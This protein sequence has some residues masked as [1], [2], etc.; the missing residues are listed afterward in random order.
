MNWREV[1]TGVR[2][3]REAI[4]SCASRI[5]SMLGIGWQRIQVKFK[6]SS[7]MFDDAIFDYGQLR[8]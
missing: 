2:W 3:M 4:R 8:L 5:V 1:I 6:N 7:K